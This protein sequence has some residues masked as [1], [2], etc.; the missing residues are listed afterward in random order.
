MVLE[1]AQGFQ[2]HQ[3]TQREQCCWL[4]LAGQQT[5][6]L[7]VAISLAKLVPHK[8]LFTHLEPVLLV[9]IAETA[10]SLLINPGP[11]QAMNA[12]DAA[13]PSLNQILRGLESGAVIVHAHRRTP[14]FRMNSIQNHNREAP[15]EKAVHMLPV[16]ANRQQQQ[17]VQVARGQFLNAALFDLAVLEAVANQHRKT[18]FI[19]AQHNVP[20]ELGEIKV[21]TIGQDKS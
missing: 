14:R 12:G 7:E 1:R 18:S 11:R 9:R 2:R 20:G 4:N 13:V 6:D 21:G 19:G 5:S 15:L 16:P 10:H 8:V 3:V 17:P